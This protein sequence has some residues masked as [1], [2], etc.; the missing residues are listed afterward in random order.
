MAPA[1]ERLL[2]EAPGAVRLHPAGS[3]PP[4]GVRSHLADGR[5]LSWQPSA[6]PPGTACAV[7]AELLATP[8]PARLARWAGCR[9]PE[10][11]WPRWTRVEASCKLRDVP[12]VLWLR[13][14]G[15]HEDPV[16]ALSTFRHHDA[17]VTCGVL[18]GS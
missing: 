2:R 13:Q 17:V 15:L 16:L 12:L 6:V 5:C 18:P 3:P 10:L 8:V 11:F 1:S 9:S 4:A 7:D 14:H